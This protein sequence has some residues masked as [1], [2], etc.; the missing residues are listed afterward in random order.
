[1]SLK[2]KSPGFWS[3]FRVQKK[4]DELKQVFDNVMITLSYERNLAPDVKVRQQQ[5]AFEIISGLDQ[6]V[7]LVCGFF[8]VWVFELI[9]AQL[10]WSWYQELGQDA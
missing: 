4:A 1:M 10:I 2:V 7:P 8:F 3:S 6:A 9:Q 5:A